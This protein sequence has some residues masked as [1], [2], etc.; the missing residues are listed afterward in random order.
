MSEPPS[1]AP[2]G[3]QFSLRGIFILITA[4][5]VILG[6]L[7]VAIREPYQ[8]LGTL[9]IIAFCL[10]VIGVIELARKLYPP[11]PRI[12]KYRT[13]P[14][15]ALHANP[16]QTLEVGEGEPPF[17]SPPRSGES[18]FQPPKQPPSHDG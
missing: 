17:H 13:T 11:K 16:L 18:P 7:A 4:V 6:L 8:W 2:T 12:P 15:R 14:L 1:T 3:S 9:G 10:M 5:S